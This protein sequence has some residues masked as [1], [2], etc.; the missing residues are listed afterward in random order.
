MDGQ[1]L[2]RRGQRP[3]PGSLGW[4]SRGGYPWFHPQPS[5]GLPRLH[6]LHL[7]FFLC[8][9]QMAQNSHFGR[10]WA[11]RGPGQ[12]RGGYRFSTTL[13][14]KDLNS[15]G[16]AGRPSPLFLC[17]PGLAVFFPFCL[18]S[19]P[20]PHCQAPHPPGALPFTTPAP[21]CRA[22]AS[23]HPTPLIVSFYLLQ[24]RGAAARGSAR[25]EGAPIPAKSMKGATGGAAKGAKKAE[26]KAGTPSRL[27]A[28]YSYVR[29]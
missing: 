10:P 1:A 4:G 26:K 23:P 28:T 25:R 22:I 13:T 5:A 27:Y 6:L 20:R 3:P 24:I 17:V 21:F 19:R 12:G 14:N 18:F 8:F 11:L 9:G 16:R 7:V 15:P 29:S 2:V